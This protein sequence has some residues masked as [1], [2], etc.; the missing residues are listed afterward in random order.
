M[1][2]T[3]A[4]LL[5]A[6]LHEIG[7]R[8]IF[9]VVGDALNPF[10]DA[11]RKNKDMQWIGVRHEEGAALAA[12]GQAK[13]TGKLAVCCG[14]TGPG[15]NHLIAGLYEAH[16]D[17]A[18][19]LAISGGV[20]AAQR[21]NDYLQENTPD[22]LFR[23]VAV[24]TQT[25]ASADQAAHVFHQAIA[26]AYGMHG[27]AHLNIPPDVFAAKT[28][29]K[30]ESLAT[31][32]ASPEMAADFEDLAVAAHLIE[33]AKK[34]AIFAG[35]G[36]RSAIAQVLALAERLQAP[37]MHTF[38][39]KDM[40][41]YTHPYWI[42]GVGLIGGAPGVDAMQ[43]ADLVIML[44]SDYPYTEYLP[45]N[46]KVIQIDLRPEVLGR[47]TGVQLGIVGAIKPSIMQLL[48][49][50]PP[51]HDQ[52]FFQ[53][54]T[55]ARNK[56]DE[57]LNKKAALKDSDKHVN[58]QALARG[59]S[60]HARSNAAIIIDT[61]VVTLWCGNWLQQSGQQ[62]ILASFN[63]AA[64]GTSLGQANG[65]QALDRD[66][67]VI[68]AVG[69][70]GFTML[71]GEFMT[72]VEHRLPVKV[73]VFNNQQWGLVHIEMEE[74]GL[75][76]D[77]ASTFPNMDFAAFAQACGASGFTVRKSAELEQGLRQLFDARGP[78]VL[79][80]FID[81]EELPSMPHVH[82]DQIW[83]FGLARVKEALLAIR[84]E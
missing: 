64:V 17:H 51:R 69:D 50:L 39:A 9:G 7:V 19:V 73:I 41:S 36:C 2:Q 68:V 23:D 54:V 12:A 48:E 78:A 3:V 10:T 71:L 63:N 72:S 84:G 43:E 46:G 79:N 56:W 61:G 53:S 59:I 20:P 25:L 27:V 38:R 70:G 31:L 15:A 62:R 30:M 49:L 35:T 33:Q 82:L 74:A 18:P 13:L 4:E 40:V 21:G 29:G 5:V 32:R 1:Q 26:H 28:D 24:Y 76:A 55:E 81:P 58:P 11:I 47:R 14:T 77:K 65:V 57:M 37:I 45:K 75:P 83:R 6:T 80:V 8:Q 34:I 44:G 60:L 67:Q 16:K 52:Q 22:L 42:G 66:R